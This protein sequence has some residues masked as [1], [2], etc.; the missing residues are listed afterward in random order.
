MGLLGSS[1]TLAILRSSR[2]IKAVGYSHR[3]Q[4]RQ[5]ARKIGVADVIADDPAECVAQADVVI[6]ATPICTFETIF[7]QIAPELKD[8]AIITD[9]GS[10]KSMP[11][12]WA[13]N[14]LGKN[15]HYVGSHPIAGSEH[16]GLEFARDDL[17]SG[18]RCILTKNARTDSSAIETLKDFWKLVGCSVSVM[19][20]AEHDKIFATVSHVP[21][22]TAAALVNASRDDH[23]KY[24][25]KGFIDTTRVSSGPENVWSD[26]LM[27][28]PA[29]I[30]RGIDRVIKELTKFRDAI[31]SDSQTKIEKLLQNARMKRA[32]LIEYKMRNKELI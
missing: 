13:A 9:V 23:V 11:H 8:G 22:I 19:T 4:T 2:G 1:V 32:K 3:D 7:E 15:V 30:A 5:K 27:T 6:L 29:N 17:F 24:S 26:I 25:G 14:K 21:H 31:T 16:S 12:K 20:P 18:S 10:T 28:N